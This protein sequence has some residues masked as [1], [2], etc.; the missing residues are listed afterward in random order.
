MPR[1]VSNET[2]QSPEFEIS[3][4]GVPLACEAAPGLGCGTIATP[5]LAELERQPGIREA[6]LNRDGTVLGISWAG[7][8]PDPAQVLSALQ[9]HNLA[10]SELRDRD[11]DRARHSFASGGWCRPMQLHELSAEEARVI[12][13][14][15][16]RRLES[17]TSLPADT[18]ER[19]AKRLEDR[20]VKVL[21]RASA[22]SFAERREQIATA[23]LEGGKDLLDAQA[24]QAFAAAVLLGHRPLAGER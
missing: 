14:R 13:A 1:N 18:A 4:F 3:F 10:G 11:H 6:W 23:L 21:V 8:G 12:A 5:V 22:T 7:R 16:V 9:R 15:L 20:C 2:T 17:K 19:L 24:F